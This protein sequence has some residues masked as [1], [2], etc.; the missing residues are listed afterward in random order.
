MPGRT[1]IQV[2]ASVVIGVFVLGLWASGVAVEASWL[3]FYSMAVFAALALLIVW[4]R[5]L[6]RLPL[7]KNAVAVPPVLHGTWRG[8]LTSLWE[9]PSTGRRPSPKEAYLVVRQSASRITVRFYTDQ[10]QSTSTLAQVQQDG[11][12]SALAYLYLSKPD[13]AFTDHSPMHHGCALLGITS[14]P[15]RRLRG[16][17]WTDRDS[18]GELDFTDHVK[19]LAGDL[20]QARGL[21]RAG[22]TPSSSPEVRP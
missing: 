17:Y 7:F 11:G 19:T 8:V 18:R 15:A 9:D 12:T 20:D 16:R 4:D 13:L 6:W 22:T 3:R 10:G 14:S 1:V 5:W 2:V 21:F